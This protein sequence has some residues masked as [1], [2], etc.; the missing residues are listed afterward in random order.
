MLQPQPS[1]AFFTCMSV[2]WF[3]HSPS[4]FGIMDNLM[5]YLLPE[6]TNKYK[7]II[8]RESQI[9]D[10]LNVHFF[11]FLKVERQLKLLLIDMRHLQLI[12]SKLGFYFSSG[13]TLDIDVL[14]CWRTSYWSIEDKTYKKVERNL[15]YT[16]SRKPSRKKHAF[17]PLY[18]WNS[19]DIYRDSA[20]I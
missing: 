8:Q 10:T 9:K 13:I 3:V 18:V 14:F 20:N 1:I 15:F 11:F 12:Q 7:K 5:G 19:L 4:W 2:L 6:N 16:C 17:M